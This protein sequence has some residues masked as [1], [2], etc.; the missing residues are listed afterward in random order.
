MTISPVEI[1][2]SLVRQLV[3]AQFPQWAE[4]AVQPVDQSGWDNRSFRLGQ[5]MVVRLPSS[6]AYATQAER[7]H[8]WLPFIAP[9]LSQ[10]IPTPLAIGE[11]RFVYPWKWSVYRWLEGDTA[12]PERIGSLREF[13]HDL[14]TFLLSLHAVS[15]KGGPVPGPDTFHRGGPLV[16]YDSDAR[17]AVD[18]LASQMN[19]KAITAVWESAL[20]SR[21]T[22]APVWVHGDMSV[23]NLLVSDGRLCGVI[24][25]GQ[26]C[27]GD[28]ACDLVP[29]WTLFD[30]ESREVFK[31]SVA[32]DQATWSRGRGWA[33]WKALIVAARLT[34]TNAWEGA[35]CWSTI[36]NVMTDHVQTD[37]S[38][39]KK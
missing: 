15:G 32:V 11:P 1:N 9:K 36:E 25:F 13:A 21:W 22:H 35:R 37:L 8:R 28:P 17:R 20:A 10:P 38:C 3:H 5:D 24:D 6:V 30:E 4:L 18:I 39:D 14:A 29:A 34:T 33:L 16:V 23:G 12:L 27:V 31:T 19:T 2:V 26:C 7:E